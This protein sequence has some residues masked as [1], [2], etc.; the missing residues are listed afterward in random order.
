MQCLWTPA[1]SAT[2]RSRRFWTVWSSSTR[3]RR[4]NA[5]W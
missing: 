2:M 4:R 5:A 1:P 3:S